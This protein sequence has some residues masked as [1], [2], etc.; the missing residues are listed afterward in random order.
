MKNQP[1]VSVVVPIYGVEKYLNQCVDSILAQTLKE[2]EIILVDDGSKDKCPQIIDEYAQKDPRVV[3]VHQPNGGYGR[4][5][6]HGLELATGEYIGI[7][8]SDDWIEPDMYEKMYQKA[9]QTNVDIVKSNF[10]NNLPKK[11]NKNKW[12]KEFAIPEGPFSFIN[13]PIF[14]YFHPSIWSCLYKSD[15]IK[16]NHIKMEEI[17]GAGWADNLFQVQSLCYTKKIAYTDD[18]FYHYRRLNKDDAKD[19]KDWHIPFN[20][21]KEIH[22]WMQQQ[23][24]TNKDIWACLYKRE[25][26][27]ICLVCRMLP[28]NQIKLALPNIVSCSRKMDSE[29]LST[30]SFINDKERKKRKAFLQH[31]ILSILYYKNEISLKKIRRFLIAVYIRPA[32]FLV[33][34]LGMQLAKGDCPDRPALIKFKIGK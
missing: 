25:L 4:A 17:P 13:Y 11:E 22:E 5:V 31:P 23:K 12:K 7:V 14:L 32:G 34:F 18:A 28:F 27:Y 6:N 30:S 20:R 21:T 16:K 29:I 10:F 8:E 33:Q 26:A 24:I 1:K 15:L 9:V 19:L 3:A 2:I